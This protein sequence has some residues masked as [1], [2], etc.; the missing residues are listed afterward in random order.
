[1]EARVATVATVDGAATAALERMA[2]MAS[3]VGTEVCLLVIVTV[4]HIL[5]F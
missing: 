3:L 5:I 1:M 2:E 4:V